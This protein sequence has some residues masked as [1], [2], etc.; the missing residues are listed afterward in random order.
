MGYV[1]PVNEVPSACQGCTP[2]RHR[3]AANLVDSERSS[4]LKNAARSATLCKRRISIP[5]RAPLCNITYGNLSKLSWI[6][7]LV[8]FQD[9]LKVLLA[10]RDKEI[11]LIAESNCVALFLKKSFF[12][13]GL[14][15]LQNHAFKG[16]SIVLSLSF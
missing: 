16:N 8:L 12:E 10:H 7:E 14:E 9:E 15:C 2:H 6:I 3:Q 5:L 11:S 13:R 4:C 1:E